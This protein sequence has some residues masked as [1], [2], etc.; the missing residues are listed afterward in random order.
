MTQLTA[1]GGSSSAVPDG[2][3]DWP[4][5]RARCL[6]LAVRLL[7][8]PEDAEE[9]VQEAMIRAWRARDDCRAPAARTAWLLQ[10]TRREALRV[11]E[12]RGRVRDREDPASQDG[13]LVSIEHCEL[14]G[15]ESRVSFDQVLRLLQPHDR[16]LVRLRYA[17]DLTQ[18]QVAARLD[19]PAGTVKVRL[20]RARE[21]LRKALEEFV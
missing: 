19:L 8:H 18:E 12:R 21:R 2:S 4:L 10:I 20:H 1:R 7:R 16:D 9:A 6:R 3:W 14:E 5:A 15:V 11:A 17:E 13:E